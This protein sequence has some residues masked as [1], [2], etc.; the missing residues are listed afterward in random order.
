MQHGLETLSL[1][2]GASTDAGWETER[3]WRFTPNTLTNPCTPQ[4]IVLNNFARLQNLSWMGIRVVPEILTLQHFL[5]ANSSNLETLN[6]GFSDW[7]T[8]EYNWE[9]HYN[10]RTSTS[11]TNFF[12][13]SVLPV[14]ENGTGSVLQSLKDFSLSSASLGTSID[15]LPD[16]LN[17]SHLRSLT[18]RDCHDTSTLL[19]CFVSSGQPIVLSYLELV[20][21]DTPSNDGVSS[22]LTEFL[23]S[24]KGLKQLHL[25]VQ[26]AVSTKWLWI[27]AANHEET[28]TDFVFHERELAPRYR[29]IQDVCLTG[30]CPSIGN[31]LTLM[32]SPGMRCLGVYDRPANLKSHIER[33]ALKPTWNM[34]H[35]RLSGPAVS[36]AGIQQ[37]PRWI[38][39]GRA[40]I[41]SRQRGDS[42]ESLK[43]YIDVFNFARWAFGPEGLPQLR[44]LAFG[45]FSHGDLGPYP[46][47][48]MLLCRQHSGS[49]SSTF[50]LAAKDDT[51][52]FGG[53][54]NPLRF[55]GACPKDP[56]L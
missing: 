50:S 16:L 44:V 14:R 26:L 38:E 1:I 41:Q 11:T 32:T 7:R 35:L 30:K 22:P 27:A 52:I 17:I 48:N 31:D 45:D 13:K 4:F 34:L 46:D 8:I 43:A 5:R 42:L 39:Q 12:T 28:L 49:F 40:N 53:I 6:L 36:P 3:L 56:I 54:E 9:L 51:D 29:G 21:E 33:Y 10:Y 15:G 55:F 47:R 18:L 2:T 24:F 37:M 20:T 23:H 25:L 19:K